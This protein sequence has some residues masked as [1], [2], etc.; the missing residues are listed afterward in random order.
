MQGMQV[1][2]SYDKRVL[3]TGA[4]GLIGKELVNPLHEAGF[5]VYAITIDEHNPDNGIHW[6]K[7][8]LFD[9]QFVNDSVAK[10]RPTHLLNMAWATTGDYLASDVNYRFLQ[11]GITLA[12]A[13]V[14][15]GGKR[16]VYAG[17]CFEY[18]FKDTPLK[19]SDELEPEKFTYTF[20]KDALRRIVSRYFALHGVSFGYGRIFYV[21]GRGENVARL[22]GMVIDKLFKN[23]R[24]VVNS[25]PLIKDYMYSR[26]IAGA[27]SAFLAS[28]ILGCVN[29][30]S[31]KGISI[32]DF[33]L[34]IAREMAKEHLIDFCDNC[35]NQPQ[36]IVGVADRLIKEV[37][38]TPQWSLTDAVAEIVC[39][40][41]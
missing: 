6:I 3:V 14:G 16:A 38:Y 29:I 36:K 28:E 23:E 27:F 33:V 41:V 10:V 15:N 18:K 5:D 24:V 4:T 8:S 31:G 9:E 12:R 21:Y 25:G 2:T 7:G 35:N 30:C 20:C 13:F 34:S 40:D 1:M 17:T 26:D 39:R 11:A 32:R 19:E 22:T 37:G